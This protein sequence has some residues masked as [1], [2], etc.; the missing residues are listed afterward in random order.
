MTAADV[1]VVRRAAARL[2]FGTQLLGRSAQMEIDGR[3]VPDAEIRSR[4]VNEN[5]SHFA[6]IPEVRTALRM[7]FYQIRYL[8]R[9]PPHAAVKESVELVKRAHKTSAAGSAI[10]SWRLMLRAKSR[11]ITLFLRPACR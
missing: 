9:V 2:N 10:A 8:E 7:G 6:A 4:L 11:V 3:A 5:V 1:P